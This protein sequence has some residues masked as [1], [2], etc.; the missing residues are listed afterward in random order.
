MALVCINSYEL[1]PFI[2]PF[3]HT[4]PNFFAN[5]P[6]TNLDRNLLVHKIIDS[7]PNKTCQ[8][9]FWQIC[10]LKVESIYSVQIFLFPLK[11]QKTWHR[12]HNFSIHL[13]VESP[14]GFRTL[15]RK[16]HIFLA[17][18]SFCGCPKSWGLLSYLCWSLLTYYYVGMMWFLTIERS[19]S[20]LQVISLITYWLLQTRFLAIL[21]KPGLHDI[22]VVAYQRLEWVAREFFCIGARVAIYN[23][24]IDGP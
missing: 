22:I 12:V 16:F 20:P 3:N 8:H 19:F 21:Q 23:L 11:F 6:R 15:R 14:V 7:F 1:K 4:S 2:F 9:F 24:R 10:F 18:T 17:L 13:Q 5:L